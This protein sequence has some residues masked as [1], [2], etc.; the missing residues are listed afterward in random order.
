MLPAKEQKNFFAFVDASQKLA[1]ATDS[2][3]MLVLLER[4]ISWKRLAKKT[5]NL[6]VL[7]V[8]T[9]S[10]QVHQ[11]A[12]EAELNS[13]LIESPIIDPRDQLA[14]AVLGSVA[15]AHIRTGSKLVALYNSS[16]E[17]DVVEAANVRGDLLALALR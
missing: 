12:T 2:D 6:E 11:S 10:E 5:A 9:H 4:E 14:Q 8:A 16:G 17:G 3:A 7:V 15:E 1:K 13:V